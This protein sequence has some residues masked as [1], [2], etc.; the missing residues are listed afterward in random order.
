MRFRAETLLM[1]GAAIFALAGLFALSSMDV[2][3]GPALASV[4]PATASAAPMPVAPVDPRSARA[5]FQGARGLC[6][7][8]DVATRLRW[9]AAPNL[10]IGLTYAA[11]C[12]ALPG[13]IKLASVEER[14]AEQRY[15]L[16][17]VP[18]GG[19]PSG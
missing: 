13:R 2:E 5:R 11:A 10:H 18:G 4:T 12:Y 3:A 8:R 1:I 6:S 7:S 17:G 15:G 19:S 9:Q 14:P 16:A